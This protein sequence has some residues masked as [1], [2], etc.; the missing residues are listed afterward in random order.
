MDPTCSMFDSSEMESRQ[1]KMDSNDAWLK[2]VDTKPSNAIRGSK[3]GLI[4]LI[5]P[6]WAC[7][8]FS[9]VQVREKDEAERRA[10]KGPHSATDAKETL[11]VSFSEDKHVM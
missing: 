10:V 5:F 6:H 2:C 7:C 9:G 8:M 11:P 4:E 1:A 3:I